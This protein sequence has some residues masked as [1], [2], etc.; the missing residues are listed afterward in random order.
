MISHRHKTFKVDRLGPVST[1]SIERLK[2]ANLNDH[3][4]PDDARFDV[5]PARFSD[6]RSVSSQGLQLALPI[7]NPNEDTFMFGT[8]AS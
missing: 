7:A 8:A 2:V 4:L 3:L 5:N 1:G 6:D